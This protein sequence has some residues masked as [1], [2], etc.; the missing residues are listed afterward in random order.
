MKRWKSGRRNLAFTLIELLVVIAIVALLFALIRPVIYDTPCSPPVGTR[1]MSNLRQIGIGSYL[2]SANH[3]DKF[4]WQAPATHGGTLEIGERG[5]VVP[6]FQTLEIYLKDPRVFFCL[7]D[8]ARR[9]A[10]S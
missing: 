10:S 9:A 3:G 6:H 1:C 2:W 7:A 4:P 8:T 5:Q